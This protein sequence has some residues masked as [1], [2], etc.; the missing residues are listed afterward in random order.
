[1]SPPTGA[2]PVAASH[3]AA[4]SYERQSWRPALAPEGR[5]DLLC[6]GT[7]LRSSG[8]HGPVA[9]AQQRTELRH[10]ERSMRNAFWNR[11]RERKYL[12][13]LLTVASTIVVQPLAHG[14]LAGLILY[15][16]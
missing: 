14:F 4:E 12:V 6:L 1:M 3:A 10:E 8:Y 7:F 9:N 16:V 15:E 11:L 13:L 5:G 2:L